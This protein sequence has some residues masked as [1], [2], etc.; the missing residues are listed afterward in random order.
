MCHLAPLL[1]GRPQPD[2]LG[3]VHKGLLDALMAGRSCS[4]AAG[5]PAK[6]RQT[7]DQGGRGPRRASWPACGGKIHIEAPLR[8][9]SQHGG[10]PRRRLVRAAECGCHCARIPN[11]RRLQHARRLLTPT[12]T[13]PPPRLAISHS[14]QTPSILRPRPDHGAFKNGSSTPPRSERNPASDISE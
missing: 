3:S 8:C 11:T 14:L 12:A 2:R 1:I 6:N 4:C 7:R 5:V 10:S 9:R 13:I